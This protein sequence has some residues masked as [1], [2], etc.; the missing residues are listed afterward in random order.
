MYRKGDVCTVVKNKELKTYM[1]YIVYDLNRY[2]CAT[3]R[4][5]L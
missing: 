3:D 2:T 5:N 4:L 1:A